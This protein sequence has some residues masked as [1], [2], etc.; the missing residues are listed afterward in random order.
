[1][2]IEGKNRGIIM[3]ESPRQGLTN[4]I[5]LTIELPESPYHRSD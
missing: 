4:A 2:N 1:M 3:G 5:D